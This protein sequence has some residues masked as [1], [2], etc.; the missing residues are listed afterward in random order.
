MG[1]EDG[2]LRILRRIEGGGLREGCGTIRGLG[3]LCWWKGECMSV[4]EGEH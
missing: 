2:Y 3:M 1:V 4:C